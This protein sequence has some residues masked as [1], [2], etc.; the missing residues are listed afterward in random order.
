MSSGQQRHFTRMG[1]NGKKKGRQVDNVNVMR[2]QNHITSPKIKK[3]QLYQA[4]TLSTHRSQCCGYCNLNFFFFFYF[5][6][7]L[8]TCRLNKVWSSNFL[9]WLKSNSQKINNVL[10]NQIFNKQTI[11]KVC[12]DVSNMLHNVHWKKKVFWIYLILVCHLIIACQ[13][14][15]FNSH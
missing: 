6:I 12:R 11:C 13:T 14:K 3:G 4:Y 15:V 2:W 8:C 10:S 5:T 7:L 9:T 1:Q